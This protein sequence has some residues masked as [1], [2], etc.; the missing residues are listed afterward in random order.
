MSP[1]PGSYPV[2]FGTAELLNDLDRPDGWLLTV[3]GVAQSYVDLDDP[4]HLEFDYVR[5]IG[6]VIDCLGEPDA[7]M[8]AVHVGGAGCT[9]PRYV[10]ATRPG[11]RQ[12]VLEADAELV[13]L[14]WSQFRLHEV[15]GLGLRAGDG[16]AGL[17]ARSAGSADLVVLDAFERDSVP[18]ALST[19]EFFADVARVLRSSGSL[20][21]NIF[22]GPGL[23]FTKRLSATLF[24]AFEHVLLLAEPR[25]LRG[26]RFDNVVLLASAEE[27]PVETLTRRA[28]SAVFPA[29]CVPPDAV[30]RLCG[31]AEP[32]TDAAPMTAPTLPK[33]RLGLFS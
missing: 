33:D 14:V 1:I 8:D 10:E 29:R 18:S 4:T 3:G 13:E 31:K 11:S 7:P 21:A 27:P 23:E 22:D 9:L 6:D 26:R 28:A 15:A 24:T 25:V 19:V 2:R 17:A 16:R 12:L 5:R 30:K 20:V 32:I